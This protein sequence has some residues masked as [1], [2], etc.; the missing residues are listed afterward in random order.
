MFWRGR[1]AIRKLACKGVFHG[2]TNQA[3]VEP[4]KLFIDTR[5]VTPLT[6]DTAEDRS[7]YMH[8]GRPL[9]LCTA[10]DRSHFNTAEDRSKYMQSGRPLKLCTAEDR[11]HFGTAG[12]RSHFGTAGDR[13]NLD[14]AEDRPKQA[15]TAED[16]PKHAQRKTAHCICFC[17]MCFATCHRLSPRPSVHIVAPKLLPDSCRSGARTLRCA[18]LGTRS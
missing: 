18:I 13:S 4:T 8:S 10:E 14:T 11:S 1:G 3:T 2:G 6:V 9:R 15:H 16:R 17:C 7:N 12:D 5:N